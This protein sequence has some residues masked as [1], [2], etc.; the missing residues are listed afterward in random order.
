VIIETEIVNLLR[1]LAPAYYGTAPQP[2]GDEPTPMPVIIVNRIAARWPFGFCGTDGDLSLVTVQADYYAET[3][4]LAR[5]LA[6]QGRLQIAEMIIGGQAVAPALENEFSM[7]DD[8]ARAWRVSQ[9]WAA[10]D[11]APSL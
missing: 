6:D 10:T 9:Q 3:A 11:Y 4:E 2:P 5:Q 7:R 8:V 1:T